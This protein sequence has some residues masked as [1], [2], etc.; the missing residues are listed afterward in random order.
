MGKKYTFKEVGEMVDRMARGLQNQGVA[1]GSK[2]GICLPNTPFYIVSFFGALK[3]GATVV[4]FNPLYTEKELKHQINDSECETMITLNVKQIFPKVE[5]LLGQSSLKNIIAC[6]MADALPL[7]KKILYMGVNGVQWAVGKNSAMRIKKSKDITPL[8]KLMK[9]NGEPRRVAID[10][11][12]DIAVLQYTGGTT[13]TPKG[14]MLTHKNLVS[15]TEQVTH[16]FNKKSAGPDKMLA[17][18]P[19]FHVFA[20]TGQMNFSVLNGI[21]LLMLPRFNPEETLKTIASEKVTMFF[22]VPTLFKA[23]SDHPKRKEYNTSSLNV[24]ISGGAALPENIKNDFEKKFG[25]PLLEGYG[26]SECSP[27]ATVG[28]V[29]GAKVKTNSIG[30]P[31]PR[32]EVKIIDPQFPDKDVPVKVAGEICLRG[33]QVMKGY[34]KNKAETDKVIDKNGFL[35]TGDVG[36]I[37]EE[38]YTFIVDRIKDIIIASGYNVYPRV[39]EEAIMKHPGVSECLVGGIKD[40][41][42]G[43]TVKAW[44]V[45]KENQKLTAEDLKTF[46]K[47]EISPIEMPKKIEFRDSLPK[48]MI[49]K[50]DRKALVAEENARM[51]A[52]KAAGNDNKGGAS[53]P[54]ANNL[55]KSFRKARAPKATAALLKH[56]KNPA[57]KKK[58]GR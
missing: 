4:N 10:P 27:V 32:T 41:Y 55:A 53:G 36:Y 47:N 26:L 8:K 57:L 1:K 35:H 33:P 20:M 40:E 28:P 16:W 39:V 12:N 58:F 24:C 50:P 56:K 17:V 30:L 6:D 21:E 9:N 42:R 44:I 13:G 11:E 37:D 51:E 52:Q 23:L 43:E 38:G 29:S 54:A 25:L 3:A 22:G 14:A 46:L 5:K 45:L 2:V 31:L 34:W 18:L 48:T 7:T 19:F 49:G 15:N